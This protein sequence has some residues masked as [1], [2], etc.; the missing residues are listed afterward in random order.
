MN[1]FEK[2]TLLFIYLPFIFRCL[3]DV[4]KNLF[5]YH[6]VWLKI[7]KEKLTLVHYVL[8]NIIVG[9]FI[10]KYLIKI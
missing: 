4:R 9:T 3:Q 7:F 5:F 2:N 6:W 8:L 1:I 10:F